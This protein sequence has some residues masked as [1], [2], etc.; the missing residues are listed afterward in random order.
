MTP[1]TPTIRRDRLDFGPIIAFRFL[2]DVDEV[3][4]VKAPD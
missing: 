2:L 3:P 4:D 1:P